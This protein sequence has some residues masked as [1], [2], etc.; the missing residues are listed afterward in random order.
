MICGASH[1]SLLFHPL[2]GCDRRGINTNWLEWLLGLP[3]KTPIMERRQSWGVCRFGCPVF[4]ARPFAVGD[5]KPW[6][7]PCFQN[8]SFLLDH[9]YFL[10]SVDRLPLKRVACLAL[11]AG[12]DGIT[13][14]S[15]FS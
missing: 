14:L 1:R 11:V 6:R 13:P 8:R 15:V 5:R 10:C 7:A 12:E 3:T 2:H 4:L 9:D